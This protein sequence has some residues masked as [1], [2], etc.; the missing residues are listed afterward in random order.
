[1]AGAD[2]VLVICGQV[3]TMKKTIETPSIHL[4]SKPVLPSH[5]WVNSLVVLARQMEKQGVGIAA[6]LAESGILPSDL[7]DPDYFVTDE[8]ERHVLRNILSL[9]KDPAIGLAVGQHYHVLIHGHLGLAAASSETTLEAIKVF[10]RYMALT[11]THFQYELRVKDAQAF[12]SMKE[13]IDLK[14]LRAFVCE[15]EFVSVFRMA[16]DILGVPIKLNEARFAYPEPP[17]ASAY[18][19]AFGCPVRFNADRYLFAFDSKYLSMPLPL[20]NPLLR[21]TYEKACDQL[22]MRLEMKGTMTERV[23]REILFRREGAP[24]FAQLARYLNLSPRTLRR[25]LT[26]EG[27]SYK[28]LFSETIT[29]KAIDLIQTTSHS[30]E[31]IASALGYSDPS[32]F[33]RAFKNWTGRNPSFYRKKDEAVR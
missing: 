5:R 2:N 25:R 16:N 24:T 28:A 6:L 20:A 7:D 3:H 10:F 33:Y 32:N 11:L 31:E 13:L 19:E 9:S 23:R 26:E 29:R 17:Y 21:K 22:C 18:Q 4:T 27:T 30:M 14:D 8:Q 15:R 12:I 1:M